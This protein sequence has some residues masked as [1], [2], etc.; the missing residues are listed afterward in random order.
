M[1]IRLDGTPA[2]VEIVANLLR[3]FE[4]EQDAFEIVAESDDYPNRPR[5][6]QSTATSKLV[7]RY[8]EIR[9]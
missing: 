1:K 8:L 5:R 4:T 9:L 6:S 7:R 3:Q 2:E